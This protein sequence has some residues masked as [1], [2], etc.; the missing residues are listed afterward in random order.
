MEE[1][2]LI[3]HDNDGG[4]TWSP[5]L[6]SILTSW[7]LFDHKAPAATHTNATVPFINMEEKE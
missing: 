2:F 6:P 7:R 4:M 5:F 3:V 1:T